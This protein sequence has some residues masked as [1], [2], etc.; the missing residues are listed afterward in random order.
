M[1]LHVLLWILGGSFAL[2]AIQFKLWWNHARDCRDFRA[3]FATIEEQMRSVVHEIGDH[4]TGI[5]GGLH[6]LRNQISPMYI[7]WQRRQRQ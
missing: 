4:E 5:R 7:D 3:R 1:D 2:N 6:Q